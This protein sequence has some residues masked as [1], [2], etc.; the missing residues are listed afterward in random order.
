VVHQRRR[1]LALAVP[2]LALL[3]SCGDP[4]PDPA[5]LL[6]DA[7]HVADTTSSLHLK[8]SSSEATG[9]GPLLLSADGDAVR[10]DGFR[11][12]VQ[13]RDHDVPVGLKVLA[14]GGRFYVEIPLVGGFQQLDPA[15]YGFGDPGALLDPHRGL[16]SLI[17]VA[18]DIHLGTAD[19]Y[20]GE[21]LEE[22]QITLPGDRVAAL[23][24][25]A[26]PSQSVSATVGIT[27]NGHQV[28]RVVMRGPFFEA[29]HQ[30]TYTI[31][32]DRYGDNVRITPPA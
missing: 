23:L 11:G 31:V 26:D 8:V 14:V 10:P 12:T 22:V 30:G 3:T 5:A 6:R 16:S 15:K 1:A 18:R 13:V 2:L 24:V 29:H 9:P 4:P 19:R 27:R 20:Q 21:E 32:M 28:R 25:S 17:D 7:R